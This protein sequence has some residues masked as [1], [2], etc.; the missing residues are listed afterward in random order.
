MFEFGFGLGPNLGVEGSSF[1]RPE[2][3]T[4]PSELQTLKPGRAQ[5]PVSGCW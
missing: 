1:E 3:P 5:R 2:T 4:A